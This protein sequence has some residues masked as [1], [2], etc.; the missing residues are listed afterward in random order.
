MYFIENLTQFVN[1]LRQNTRVARFLCLSVTTVK[2]TNIETTCERASECYRRVYGRIY[3]LQEILRLNPRI[4][5]KLENVKTLTVKPT[6][7][8]KS[9][10]ESSSNNAKNHQLDSWNVHLTYTNRISY[11]SVG[12]V[13]NRYQD[14]RPRLTRPTNR[15]NTAERS[16]LARAVILYLSW[17]WTRCPYG[18]PSRRE[19][20]RSQV[21]IDCRKTTTKTDK[22]RRAWSVDCIKCSRLYTECTLYKGVAGGILARHFCT[23][24]CAQQHRWDCPVLPN[25]HG[26]KFWCQVFIVYARWI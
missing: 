3:R 11:R 4:S 1:L 10:N 9:M 15:R 13:F 20:L 18:Q 12:T 26:E 5:I 23:L 2:Y 22:K 17:T 19:L 14:E 25:V 24:H 8:K 21:N 6:E 16:D 7:K